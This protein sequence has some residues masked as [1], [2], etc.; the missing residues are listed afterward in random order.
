MWSCVVNTASKSVTPRMTGLSG[1]NTPERNLLAP[2]ERT[3]AR[4][5]QTASVHTVH[6]QLK[7]CAAIIKHTCSDLVLPCTAQYTQA[8]S[9]QLQPSPLRQ[10]VAST[11]PCAPVLRPSRSH[12]PMHTSTGDA[13]NKNSRRCAQREQED[14]HALEP[15]QMQPPGSKHRLL[16][17]IHL[18]LPA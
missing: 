9:T 17:S 6:R 1:S 10:R 13:N 15:L 3:Q 11:T 2:P 7:Y 4:S 14:K 16:Q 5:I 8:H 12:N 18:S